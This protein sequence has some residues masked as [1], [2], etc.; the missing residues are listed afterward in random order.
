MKD[1]ILELLLGIGCP[2]NLGMVL[3]SWKR[4]KKS[5]LL[6]VEFWSQWCKSVECPNNLFM[7]LQSWKF[8]SIQA[9]KDGILELL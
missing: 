1:G 6:K 3:Q 8:I 7:V 2:H 4:H 9:V 5:K